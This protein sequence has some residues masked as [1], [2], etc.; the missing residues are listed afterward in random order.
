MENKVLSVGKIHEVEGY[1]Y[2]RLRT[3]AYF[4]VEFKQGSGFRHVFQT[5][6]PKNG[7]LNNPKKSTYCTIC[8]NEAN[9]EN[10][11]IETK[12]KNVYGYKEINEISRFV[13]EN[14]SNLEL[15]KGMVADLCGW[16]MA[17]IRGNLRYERN[18][19]RL[20]PL[21]EP[22]IHLLVQGVKTGENIFSQIS[23]NLEEIDAVKKLE[24]V[25][26]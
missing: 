9:P 6:N 21:F 13:A 4:S 17:S 11:H 15:T 18:W 1:P 5:V 24:P 26:A 8:W 14:W 19:E 7:K 12:S 23:L 16:L 3:K 25:E 22:T 2:G 20:K 10:G